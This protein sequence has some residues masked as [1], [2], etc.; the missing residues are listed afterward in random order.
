[1]S[2]RSRSARQRFQ[3]AK[4]RLRSYVWSGRREAAGT[5]MARAFIFVLDSFGMGGAPDAARFGDEGADTFGHIRDKCAAG[6]GDREG[7]RAGP[8]KLPNLFS[9][10]LHHA[11]ALATGGPAPSH[12]LAPGSFHGAATEI[13][14]G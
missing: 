13:S 14:S 8:L 1:V 2:L 3:I 6:E 10:G 9:L 11:S 4:F 12:L 5:H 7:L